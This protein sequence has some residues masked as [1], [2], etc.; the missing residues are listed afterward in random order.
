VDWRPVRGLTIDANV[1]ILDATLTETIAPVTGA[2]TLVGGSGDR[3]PSS[4]KFSSNV[5]VQQ[6]FTITD[7]WTAFVGANWS[8]IGN[9]RSA[10]IS[11]AAG[12]PRF[13]FP[14]YS[15]IDL[16]AGL[17]YGADWHLNLFVRNVTDK[18]GVIFADN[19]NG[20]NFNLGGDLVTF[21]TFLQPRTIG[22]SLAK[23][24]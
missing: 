8:Y 1:S 16:R 9:R 17:N 18:R 7:Q 3:L 19:R 2:D 22:F 14:S 13:T 24:F 12:A 10:F 6:D 15:L 4:A 23:E 21:A 11:T 20:T 5:F